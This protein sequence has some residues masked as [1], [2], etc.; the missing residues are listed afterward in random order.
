MGSLKATIR[1]L[2]NQVG[3][4]Y[5]TLKLHD[6]STVQFPEASWAENYGRNSERL[7][8]YYRG[9]P[10]PDPHPFGVAL[11]TARNLGEFLAKAA[12]SQRTLENYLQRGR[13][14]MG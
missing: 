4:N 9:D 2:R 7:N 13:L 14:H 3:Q 12:E 11:L 8:A 10:I 6:G 5:V 1:A